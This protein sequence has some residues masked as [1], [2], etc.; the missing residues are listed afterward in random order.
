[1]TDLCPQFLIHELKIKNYD[2]NYNLLPAPEFLMPPRKLKEDFEVELL[3]IS[4]NRLEDTLKPANQVQLKEA[5]GRL[6]LHKGVGHYTD[7]QAIALIN[8]YVKLLHDCP[9]DLLNKACDECILDPAMQY[10]P[11]VGTIRAKMAREIT[12]RQLYLGRLRKILE[13]SKFKEE[14]PLDIRPKELGAQLAERFKC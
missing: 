9:P 10:F 5:L 13:I 2:S 4:I 8:D 6:A 3:Q 1:M 7:G 14:R 11:Q 12:I